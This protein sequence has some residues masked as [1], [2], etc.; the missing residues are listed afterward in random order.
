MREQASVFGEVA[1]LYDRAR[2]GYADEV[3]DRVLDFAGVPA[4][5]LNALEI[6][7]GTGKATVAFAARGVH[8]LALEPDDAMAA[9]AQRNCERFSN[10]R[11]ERATFEDADLDGAGFDLVFAAQAWHWVRPEVR[12]TKAAAVLHR[13]GTLAVIGHRT[14]WHGE[15]L[16]ADLEEVYRR[17]VPDLYAKAPGFPGLTSGATDHDLLDELTGSGLFADASA[18]SHPWSPTFT[19][20][21]LVDLLLTQS[22]HRLLDEDRRALLLA[23]VRR[24]VEAHGGEVVV[25][26]VTA[27]VLARSR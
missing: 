22:D 18:H 17:L 8:I 20:D 21:T 11:I 27:L 4:P 9:L 10:V 12:S 26:A 7:A 16:H 2:A 24:V 1:P 13:G 5:D 3:V 15:A 25:P 6:G 23:E 19:A 14:N